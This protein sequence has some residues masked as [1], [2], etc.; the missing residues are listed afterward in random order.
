MKK[1][2]ALLFLLLFPMIPIFAEGDEVVTPFKWGFSSSAGIG[3]AQ[4]L[5]EDGSLSECIGASASHGISA[6]VLD[7]LFL[8]C[9]VDWS[10]G[11]IDIIRSSTR[12]ISP[13]F[14]ALQL[15]VAYRFGGWSN[16]L[17][18]KMAGRYYFGEREA[19]VPFAT[20]FM[21]P[22]MSNANASVAWGL[23]DNPIALVVE[24]GGGYSF[25]G[26]AERWPLG[27][28]AFSTAS[29]TFVLN[30]SYA[31]KSVLSG[32][33]SFVPPSTEIQMPSGGYSLHSQVGLVCSTPILGKKREI[34][35][36]IQTDLSNPFKMPQ[37]FISVAPQF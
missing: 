28:F 27:A 15:S 37:V 21:Y 20:A 18:A 33:Y 34:Q 2:V 1:L 30:Q 10:V 36:G 35:A 4:A 29:L 6:L 5:R 9:G 19:I 26:N 13:G 3:Y 22:C 12:V 31:V 32:N 11:F 17:L 14:D 23:I 8:N 7:R 24:G 25:G 16:F